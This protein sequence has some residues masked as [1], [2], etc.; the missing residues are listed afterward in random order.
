VLK[1]R[2]REGKKINLP[3]EIISPK[4]KDNIQINPTLGTKN[5][6]IIV[7]PEHMYHKAKIIKI[8]RG[9]VIKNYIFFVVLRF[10]IKTLY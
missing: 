5:K 7:F 8:Y 6:I 4:D 10:K 2:M 9:F 3:V 1:E